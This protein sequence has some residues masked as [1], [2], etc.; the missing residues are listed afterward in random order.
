MQKVLE[1]ETTHTIWIYE[2][3]VSLNSLVNSNYYETK[4]QIIINF[5]YK[6]CILKYLEQI[7]YYMFSS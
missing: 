5:I 4:V 6:S 3:R 7:L 1:G 2:K